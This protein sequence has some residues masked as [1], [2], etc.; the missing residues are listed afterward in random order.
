[1]QTR[2]HAD[3]A[4]NAAR[5]LLQ[6]KVPTNLVFTKYTKEKVAPF[7]GVVSKEK[8]SV[9]MFSLPDPVLP[10]SHILSNGNYSI[11]ITDRGT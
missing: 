5:L 1:M 3:P 6:E 7:K 8:S 2:F 10:K 9:R 11:M 4:I